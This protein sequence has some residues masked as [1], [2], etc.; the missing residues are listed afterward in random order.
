MAVLLNLDSSSPNAN[1]ATSA[2]IY[3][4]LGSFFVSASLA[5]LVRSQICEWKSEGILPQTTAKIV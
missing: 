4:S 2:D 5:L 1:T 3:L